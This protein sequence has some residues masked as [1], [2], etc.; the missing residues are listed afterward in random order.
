MATTVAT[1]KKQHLALPGG[2][3]HSA[4][5]WGVLDRILEDDRIELEANL[6]AIG[7]TSSIDVQK[8]FL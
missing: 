4:F 5:T 6:D 2:G 7:V 1:R 8:H 3:T